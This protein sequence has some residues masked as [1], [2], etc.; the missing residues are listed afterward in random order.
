MDDTETSDAPTSTPMER[1]PMPFNT[2][3]FYDI[4]NLIKGYG[5]ST[6]TITN[7]SLKEILTALRQTGKI[8]HIAVQRA[9]ANWSDPRLGIMRDEINELGIDPIQVFGFARE[10]KRNAADVQLAIDA[11]DL[12]YIRPGL[13]VFVIVSGDGG[14]AALAKKLHEYGKTVIGCAYRSAVN[15]TF[16]AVCDEFVWITDPEEKVQPAHTP[17]QIGVTDPRN[18]RLAEQ[19]LKVTEPT[20]ENIVAK[21]REI[22][23]WYAQN[24][25]TSVDLVQKG[26]TLSVIKEAVMYAIPDFQPG[27][28]GFA[29]FIEYM[30]FVCQGTIYC[31]VRLPTSQ[32]VLALRCAVPN[33]SEVLPDL[34]AH[35]MECG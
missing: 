2:A 6:Q 30:Q 8:G 10:P 33:G 23:D 5:F 22:L 29:K 34:D 35:E 11:I 18:I 28:L 1:T 24:T 20:P 3:I 7:V 9:Y 15:K 12:A 26:I 32:V 14:F 25:T 31:I 4:E 17:G 13:D 27:R 19:V 16:Q 21:T